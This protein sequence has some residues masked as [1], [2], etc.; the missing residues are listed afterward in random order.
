MEVL[1]IDYD[2]DS[3]TISLLDNGTRVGAVSANFN[4]ISSVFVDSQNRRNGYGSHLLLLAEQHICSKGY[5]SVSLHASSRDKSI[6]KY[7]L[8]SF[9][10]RNGYSTLDQYEYVK[11]LST[12]CHEQ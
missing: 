9:Y 3:F 12:S 2:E 4:Y 6:T 7:N 5:R 8:Y 1:V 11:V 10:T